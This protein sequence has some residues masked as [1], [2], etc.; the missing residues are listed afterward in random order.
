[1]F[2]VAATRLVSYGPDDIDDEDEGPEEERKDDEP[3]P[4]P[5]KYDD[6][7]PDRPEVIYLSATAN[8]SQFLVLKGKKYCVP[9]FSFLFKYKSGLRVFAI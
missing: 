3:E 7:S 5:S 8:G 1:M 9:L 6:E 2:S 4:K